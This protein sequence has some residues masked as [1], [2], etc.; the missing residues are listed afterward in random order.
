MKTDV[1]VLTGP[2]SCG[3]STLAQLLADHWHSPLVPEVAREYLSGKSAYKKKDLLEIAKQQQALEQEALA[4]CP[5]Q[6][7][8]RA[9][10]QEEAAELSFLSGSGWDLAVSDGGVYMTCPCMVP[11]IY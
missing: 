9:Q 2:E 8:G 4:D 11:E 10:A 5:N 6:T 3:K 7:R 1:I